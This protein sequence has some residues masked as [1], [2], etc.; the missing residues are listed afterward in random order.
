MAEKTPYT[1]LKAAI[2]TLEKAQAEKAQILKDQFKTTSE[3]LNPV[4]LIK[5]SVANFIESSEIKTSLLELLVMF[6]TGILSRKASSGSRRKPGLQQAGIL[7]LD[8]I[9]RFI[10]QN[11]EVL[12][13]V[14]NFITKVVR[15]KKATETPA[16]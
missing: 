4:N 9:G 14:G 16:D 11:P 12:K 13:S 8:G 10:I 6:G 2:Q 15:K 3:N 5:N 1:D 7:M